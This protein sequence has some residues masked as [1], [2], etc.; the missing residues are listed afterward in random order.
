MDLRDLAKLTERLKDPAKDDGGGLRYGQYLQVLL[1]A[2][3]EAMCVKRG[4]DMVEDG[5]RGIEGREDFQ[6]DSCIYAMEVQVKAG[7][8]GASDVTVTE[9]RSYE[10]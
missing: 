1:Y 8:S 2:N 5:I 10:N 7:V 4:L 3:D 9:K 6:I